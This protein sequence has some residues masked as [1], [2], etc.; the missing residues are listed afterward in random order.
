MPSYHEAW[1]RHQQQRW[2]RPDAARWVRPDAARFLA[3]GA[4]VAKAFPAL[5]RKY[6]PNQPRVPAGNPDGGQWTDGTATGGITS[7]SLGT[8]ESI[9]A[10]AGSLG[11]FQIAPRDGSFEGVQLAGDLPGIGDNGGPA[12]DESPPAIPSSEPDTRAERMRFVRAVARWIG[13]VGR[14]APA[15]GAYFEALD[16]INDLKR[17]TDVIRTANDPPATLEEL[18]ARAQ[19]PSEA[20]YEDHHIV[21]Q[22]AQ[23]R[24]QFGD[25]RIDSPENTV[26]I[27]TLKHLDINGWYSRPNDR[28]GG[29]SPRDY[30]RGKNWDEQLSIGLEVLRDQGVLK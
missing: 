7:L 17:L 14:V 2:L 21:G 23:N 4:D 3:P 15:V 20:G 19:L 22:L 1:L 10:E 12:L 28:F 26:R 18:Q 11:L 5:A 25:G 9:A 29:L 13:S 27:P 6:S 24:Q 16:Q 8:H 30:L